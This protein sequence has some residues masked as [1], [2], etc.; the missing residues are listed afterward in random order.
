MD[1]RQNQERRGGLSDRCVKEI[2]D[3]FAVVRSSNGLGQDSANVNG[4]ELGGAF[5]DN[6][7]Q[8]IRICNND[9]KVRVW[10]WGWGRGVRVCVY[11]CANVCG[12][13]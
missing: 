7:I 8:W 10:R 6:V 2:A 3:T 9:L 1:G 13:R 11:A 4:L 5:P 12:W